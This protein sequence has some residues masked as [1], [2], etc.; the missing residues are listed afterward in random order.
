MCGAPPCTDIHHDDDDDDSRQ[1]EHMM[2][3]SMGKFHSAMF[4]GAAVLPKRR[5]DEIFVSDRSNS[6]TI[7]TWHKVWLTKLLLLK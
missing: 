3:V 5:F 7:R 2:L 6:E 1:I 4:L